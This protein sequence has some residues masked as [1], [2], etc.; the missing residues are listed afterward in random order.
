VTLACQPG[1][2]LKF[3]LYYKEGFQTMAGGKNEADSGMTIIM[4]IGLGV[5]MG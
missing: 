1:F 3:S 4:L 2:L 5:A